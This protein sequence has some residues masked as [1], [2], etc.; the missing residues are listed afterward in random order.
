[1]QIDFKVHKKDMFLGAGFFLVLF[2]LFTVFFVSTNMLHQNKSEREQKQLYKD[3]TFSYNQGDLSHA[4]NLVQ[5]FEE[6]YPR[7]PLLAKVKNDFF[8]NKNTSLN[9]EATNTEKELKPGGIV[10]KTPLPETVGHSLTA[11]DEKTKDLVNN[12]FPAKEKK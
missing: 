5:K 7:S 8:S 2:L 4:K 6:K 3:I 1:M 12:M 11:E 10:V 9:G